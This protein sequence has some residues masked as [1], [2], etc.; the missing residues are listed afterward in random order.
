MAINFPEG[1]QNFPTKIIQIIEGN[2]ATG[3][4]TSSTNYG[5]IGLD[6][7]ITPKQSSNK[8]MVWGNVGGIETSAANTYSNMRL[9]RGG[10]LVL[11]H[12][13]FGLGFTGD[14]G[15]IGTNSSFHV[16]DSPSTTSAVTYKIMAANAAGSGTITFQTNSSRSCIMLM[17]VE[18]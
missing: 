9:Y 16:L 10:D 4:S 8:I 11:S 14:S 15:R 1:T 12:I 17:E 6:A 13:D 5:D 18:A 2:T 3:F 7:T